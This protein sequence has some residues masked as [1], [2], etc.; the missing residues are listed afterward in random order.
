[1]IVIGREP[2]SPSLRDR[3]LTISPVPVPAPDRLRDRVIVMGHHSSPKACRWARSRAPGWFISWRED[4]RPSPKTPARPAEMHLQRRDSVT[5][6]TTGSGRRW[7]SSREWISTAASHAR[8]G[9][10]R[11][12][13]IKLPSARRCRHQALLA[14]HLLAFYRL[15]GEAW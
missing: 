8:S 1:M 9:T 2:P 5:G 10:E 7:R 13:P 12:H 3:H 6:A 11:P 4:A 15:T 14:N